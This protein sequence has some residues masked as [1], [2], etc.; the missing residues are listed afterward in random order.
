MGERNES[1]ISNPERYR[2]WGLGAV[3]ALGAV[4]VTSTIAYFHERKRNRENE[5]TIKRMG[6]DRVVPG[7]YNPAGLELR[8]LKDRELKEEMERGQAGLLM[9]DVRALKY[10]NERVGRPEGDRLLANTGERIQ[11]VIETS[12]RRRPYEVAEERRRPGTAR[13]DIVSRSEG[14]EFYVVVR[15]V[16]LEQL[17]MISQR[18]TQRFGVERAIQDCKEGKAPIVA[19]VAHIHTSEIGS[20]F[21]GLAEEVD[22]RH[23]PLKVAQYDEMWDAVLEIEPDRVRPADDRHVIAA[24]LEVCCPG[25]ENTTR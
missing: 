3:V 19:S 1:H 23:K 2:Q 7:A 20:D 22:A 24:F 11:E 16:T 8:L 14:D 18:I 10:F 4:A 9:L 5:A 12:F 13:E 15:G 17:D 21:V 6:S 25:F